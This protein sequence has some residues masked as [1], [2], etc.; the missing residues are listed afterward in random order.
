MFHKYETNFINEAP[1]YTQINYEGN[2]QKYMFKKHFKYFI[3]AISSVLFI[4]VLS[5]GLGLTAYG[6]GIESKSFTYSVRDHINKIIPKG[7]YTTKESYLVRTALG[8]KV[9]INP[10]TDAAYNDPNDVAIDM[11]KDESL[12]SLQY[13]PKPFIRPLVIL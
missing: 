12:S 2:E 11:W 10:A 13:G 3:L 8:L 5:I 7:K 4:T 9:G 1:Y 6:L